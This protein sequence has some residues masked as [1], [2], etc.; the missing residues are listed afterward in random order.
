MTVILLISLFLIMALI[1]IPVAVALGMTSFIL[2]YFELHVPLTVMAQRIFSGVDSFPLM[3][4]PFFVLAGS[5]MNT[6][7]IT[8]RIVDFS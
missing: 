4:I 5:A 1:G 6:G 3:A 7:G 8:Q 2:L